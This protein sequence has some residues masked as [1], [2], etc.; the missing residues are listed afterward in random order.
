MIRLKKVGITGFRGARD[1][2][3]VDFGAD[4]KSMAIFGE[5]ASGKSTITDGIE[6]FYWDRVDHLW[7]ENCMGSALRNVLLPDTESAS[8]EIEFNAAALKCKK[9]I[10][11]TLVVS[12]SNKSRE[13]TEYLAKVQT[14]HERLALRNI[15]ILSFVLERK[16]EKRQELERIIGY[17]A[18]NEFREI[19]GKSLY[20]AERTSEYSTA[21]SN[22]QEYQGEI[23][24]IAR[25]NI[26][27]EEQLFSAAE[28]I[29]A[30]VGT[31]VKVSD[32]NSYADTVSQLRARIRSKDQAIKRA[33]IS[34]CI[35]K[36]ESLTKKIQEVTA[37]IG[38][39]S[40]AYS[41]L[42][43]S[44][45]QVRQI[46]LGSFLSAGRDAIVNNLV[47]VDVCP[48]CLQTIQWDSLRSALESR[49]AALADSKKKYDVAF[50]E[51]GRLQSRLNETVAACGAF[52]GSARNV[53]LGEVL[54]KPVE[55]YSALAT[56]IVRSVNESFEKCEPI[57]T[58]NEESSRTAVESIGRSIELL[59]AREL[60]LELSKE[61]QELLDAIRRLD[62]LLDRFLKYRKASDVVTKFEAQIQTLSKIKERFSLL[63]ATALQVALNTMSAD[64]SKYYLAMHP[65][66]DVDQIR[67]AVIE[68][69][70]EFEYE[71][72]GK[73]VFPPLK[74]LSESHLN[75]IGIAAFLASAK[76]FNKS[77]NF[78]LLD[79]VVTSF[80]S[81][82][83]IRLLRLLKDEFSKWQVIVLTHERFWFEMIKKELVPAGWIVSEMEAMPGK[84][85]QIKTSARSP[86]EQIVDASNNGTLNAND[87]RTA[88]ERILKDLGVNLEVKVAFRYNDENER[89]M[90]AELLN[91]LRGTLNKRSP[92]VVVGP[93]FSRIEVCK[94]VV[95]SGSHDSGAPP[96]PGDIEA[97]F[98]D[99]VGFVSEFYCDECGSYVGVE[100]L[101]RHER[102]IHCKCG[103][104][105]L[106]WKE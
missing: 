4:S 21:K 101:V 62:T 39:F 60:A 98:E 38:S 43:A 78:F 84:G 63:H 15:D 19:I 22:K 8:V 74:Y 14:G 12:Q 57:S 75:S 71:F 45:E 83:R 32:A 73:R 25:A 104:K 11:S 28:Y 37:S 67:L 16:A 87:L 51:K 47:P 3:L 54:V 50:S 34:D 24:E 53:E 56:R 91:A 23:L 93:A 55:E 82:H 41:Q 68:D 2:L 48:L 42:I 100:R 86:K 35:E 7:R 80:D 33:A 65:K 5:N 36:S 92:A 66:E 20:T 90:V 10:S 88:L 103:K 49:I 61:E 94:L 64:I 58:D 69:G 46:R 72:H 40:P 79:D 6:W 70:V 1:P 13:L 105:E 31:T 59:K 89:R 81:N 27:T 102:K 99:V 26:V 18:L 76:I 29:A 106:A 52:L 9:S 95:T 30:A 85:A 44:E 96:P 17:E 77:N 97:S